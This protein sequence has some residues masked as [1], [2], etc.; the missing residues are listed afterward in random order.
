MDGR[1]KENKVG[2]EVR[3]KPMN[4]AIRDRLEWMLVFESAM[5]AVIVFAWYGLRE[6]LI[7]APGF[8]CVLKHLHASST[9]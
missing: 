4:W 1:L 5:V 8:S 6:Q 7:L 9:K 3:K 2:G